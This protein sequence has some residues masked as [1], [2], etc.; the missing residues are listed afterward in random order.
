MSFFV[1][2]LSKPG[3]GIDERLWVDAH[4]DSAWWLRWKETRAW[5]LGSFGKR[6]FEGMVRLRV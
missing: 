2:L 5:A 3:D 6:V 1:T 4:W